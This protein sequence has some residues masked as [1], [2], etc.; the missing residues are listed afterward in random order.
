MK[1][2]L[3]SLLTWQG[4]TGRGQYV[5]VGILG[6]ALKHNLDRFIATFAF[7]RPWSIFNYWVPPDDLVRWSTLSVADRN[8]LL[9]MLVVSLPFIWVGVLLTMKRLRDAQLPGILVAFFFFPFLNL[10]FFC[11]SRYFPPGRRE[12]RLV[13]Q[14]RRGNF[15]TLSSPAMD[16]ALPLVR[17]S[18]RCSS[19]WPPPASAFSSSS[20]TGGA[21]SSGFPS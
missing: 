1:L 17:S 5:L 4:T 9:T 10:I 21:S 14:G 6:F 16:L 11:C 15:S 3:R 2:S 20:N 13:S 19:P 7:N 8:F 18:R 12:R